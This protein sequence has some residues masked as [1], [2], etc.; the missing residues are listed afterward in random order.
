MR[1]LDSRNL[2]LTLLAFGQSISAQNAAAE[3]E[4]K[5][6]AAIPGTTDDLVP[7]LKEENFLNFIKDNGIVMV[8]FY[9]PCTIYAPC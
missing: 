8:K 2:F 7:Q 4:F 3:K 1:F 5:V 6:D 9:A